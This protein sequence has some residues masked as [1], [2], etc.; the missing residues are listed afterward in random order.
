MS[1]T[2]LVV[3]AGSSSIKF[4]LF[5]REGT[6]GRAEY[7]FK[8]CVPRPKVSPSLLTLLI[9]AQAHAAVQGEVHRY[10]IPRTD[11]QVSKP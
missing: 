11:L 10:A 5:T 1:E 4:Q 9:I 6:H 7:N 2:I 8:R 3:N